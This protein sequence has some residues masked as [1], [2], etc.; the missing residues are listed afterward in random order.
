MNSLFWAI[1]LV[2]FIIVVGVVFASIYAFFIL[3]ETIAFLVIAFVF[4]QCGYMLFDDLVPE[5]R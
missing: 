4:A 5:R 3:G 2:L 1:K